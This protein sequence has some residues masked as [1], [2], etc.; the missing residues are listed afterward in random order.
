LMLAREG[1]YNDCS[2]HRLVPGFMV[3][4]QSHLLHV[5]Q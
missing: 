2:F 3:W 5:T 1:K 4:Y